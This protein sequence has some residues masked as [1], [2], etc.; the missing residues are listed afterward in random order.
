M[1]GRVWICVAVGVAFGLAQPSFLV[2]TFIDVLKE[3]KKA[4]QYSHR[5]SPN[6]SHFPFASLLHLS[7]TVVRDSNLLQCLLIDCPHPN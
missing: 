2:F 4:L 7:L 6:L 1:A 5:Q 3:L